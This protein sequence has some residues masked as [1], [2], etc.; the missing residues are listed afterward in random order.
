MAFANGN[1]TVDAAADESD[2][3]CRIVGKGDKT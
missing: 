1:E 2:P 3:G